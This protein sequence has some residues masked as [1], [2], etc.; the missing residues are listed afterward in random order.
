MTIW[1]R[2]KF[3]RDFIN[4]LADPSPATLERM[5]QAGQQSAFPKIKFVENRIKI[6]RK[7]EAGLRAAVGEKKSGSNG[8]G[9][10]YSAFDMLHSVPPTPSEEHEQHNFLASVATAAAPPLS[11]TLPSSPRIST[12]HRP[13][14]PSLV[15]RLNRGW[16]NPPPSSSRPGSSASP[17]SIRRSSSVL[18]E[19][20]RQTRVFYRD[21]E[22][23][24]ER[25]ERYEDDS[26]VP[27]E[28]SEHDVEEV[29][30][31]RGG[32]SK[33]GSVGSVVDPLVEMA[34][35]VGD[36]QGDDVFRT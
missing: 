18:E 21:R 23:E 30:P 27:E 36:G 24:E 19:L 20:S 13:S 11:L 34:E 2:V 7:I 28:D 26:G 15:R 25:H 12:S 4:I 5:I 22:D 17:A 32:G 3:P 29:G 1:P 16:W 10:T 35:E 31:Q 9:T 8:R 6:E 33:A 14:S